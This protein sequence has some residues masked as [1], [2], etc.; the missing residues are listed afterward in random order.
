VA[1]R[2]DHPTTSRSRPASRSRG[3]GL[4]DPNSTGSCQRIDFALVRTPGGR[5]PEVVHGEVTGTSPGDR[6]P[7]TGLWP[8]DHGGVV[9]RLRDL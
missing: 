9:L 1:T 8:S 2:P 6:N 5:V 4:D 7:V 3:E